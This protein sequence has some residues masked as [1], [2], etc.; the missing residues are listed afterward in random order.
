MLAETHSDISQRTHPH[1]PINK[2][3]SLDDIHVWQNVKKDNELAFS[4]LYKKYTPRLYSY[5]MHSCHDHDLVMDCLQELFASIW[6]KRKNLSA[7]H[8]VSSYLFKSFRRLL[9]KKLTW[10][11]RF[12][13]SIEALQERCFEISLSMEHTMEKDELDQERSEKLKRCVASL[14]KRQREAIFLKF[15][16]DL[17]YSDIASIMDLQVDSVYNII[18]KA[19]DCLRQQLKNTIVLLWAACLSFL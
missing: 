12:L 1:L 4:I 16:N 5:G 8:S 9:M 7:V 2:G 10:R 13:L 18:S 17:N 15:Y 11:K 14:T 6:H 3:Q 19:I